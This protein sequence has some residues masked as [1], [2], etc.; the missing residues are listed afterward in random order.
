MNAL[1]LARTA[2]PALKSALNNT[3]SRRTLATATLE[4]AA[5]AS[6]PATQGRAASAPIPLS[7][8][9]AQWARLSA[10]EKVSVHE[11]LEVLQ[12]KDWKE[13]SL[14]EKKAAYYVAFGPHGPRTPSSQ[15]GDNV[16]ILAATAG[17]VGAAG[18]LYFV[19]KQFAQPLPKTMTKEW[20]E[21]SN[22]RAI[23]AKI[24]PITGIS[25]E[26]YTGKGFVQ[27]K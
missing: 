10:E 27:S 14:D 11:Q 21:A 7:N 9:E 26:G 13:L 1:R 25:S 4:H 3:A 22:E 15:P 8:I 5:S 20:Q 19:L 2:T 17:L 12:Q 16:K 23:E 18:V 24:N 6:S